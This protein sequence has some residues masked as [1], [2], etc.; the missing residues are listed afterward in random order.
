MGRSP[1]FTNN[2]KCGRKELKEARVIAFLQRSEERRNTEC[3][4]ALATA[5][6][7]TK[8][9]KEKWLG[10]Q[11]KTEI[12]NDMKQ[13]ERK[14]K[15]AETSEAPQSG[16]TRTQ[17]TLCSI[18]AASSAV[19]LQGRGK[20]CRDADEAGNGAKCACARYGTDPGTPNAPVPRQAAAVSVAP[21]GQ[22]SRTLMRTSDSRR[23]MDKTD[24]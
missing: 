10:L 7:R 2:Q 9:V 5:S 11:L 14:E 24:N 15:S 6:D 20:D 19:C 13:R 8:F 23:Q 21:G 22:T 17:K 12:W 16:R 18:A 4:P 3:K 1:I